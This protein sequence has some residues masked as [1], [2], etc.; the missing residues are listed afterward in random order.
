MAIPLPEHMTFFSIHQY[1]NRLHSALFL[2]LMAPLLAF[3]GLHL[4]EAEEGE[5]AHHF[6][7]LIPVALLVWL[8]AMAIFNKKI[9]SARNEQGLGAKLE[10]YFEI[11]IVRYALFSC[12]SLLL[13][14][15][16]YFSR[17]ELFTACYLGGLV[18]GGAL[19]PFAAKVCRDLKLKGDER[20][21]VYFKKDN[22]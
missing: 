19:W 21:M 20:E 18:L 2:L 15:G 5:P 22:L 4:T 1:F 7:A 13:A 11:T 17:S 10:K 12:G 3:I 9:K 8:F 16:L 14:L 6:Y